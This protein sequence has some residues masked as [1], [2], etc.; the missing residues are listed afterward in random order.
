MTDPLMVDGDGRDENP[1]SRMMYSNMGI[2]LGGLAALILCLQGLHI[3][4]VIAILIIL[5]LA[6]M[7]LVIL[8]KV[9]ARRAAVAP[10]GATTGTVTGGA[11]SGQQPYQRR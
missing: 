1:T 10:V 5:G 6:V 8:K 3:P 2:V 4:F 7:N 9:Q 11:A